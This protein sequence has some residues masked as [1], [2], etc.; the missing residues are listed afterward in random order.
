MDEGR[1]GARVVASA[2]DLRT[3]AWLRE[4]E[5]CLAREEAVARAPLTVALDR[6][7]LDAAVGRGAPLTVAYFGGFGDVWGGSLEGVDLVLVPHASSIDLA[8]RRGAA[9][10]SIEVV[11]PLGLPDEAPGEDRESALATLLEGV[12]L[13]PDA[14]V[15]VVDAR[16][17][18]EVGLRVALAQLALVA[19]PALFVFDVG[20][21]V[22]LADE[23][24]R[25]VPRF[26]LFAALVAEPRL[27][28]GLLRAAD[29]ALV[30]LDDLRALVATGGET[31]LLVL[32][33]TSRER[34][35]VE[36]LAR[37]GVAR[38]SSHLALLAVTI[39]AALSVDALSAARRALVAWQ[40]EA[41]GER[42]VRAL[43]ALIERVERAPR[44]LPE[45]VELLPREPLDAA[46]GAIEPL[47]TEEKARRADEA[48]QIEDELEALK[49]R[50]S[51]G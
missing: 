22:A 18:Q 3:S 23:L 42:I 28:H 12:E 26:G 44:G 20:D 19:L 21:D 29:L 13:P 6:E 27:A 51:G 9:R 17:L 40:P 7:S 15:V 48:R 24:R 16:V 43:A 2:N 30:R 32:A 45:G 46:S 47:V 37:E 35:A 10:A 11:G 34:A 25:I 49:Q 4:L 31:G 50:I 41:T 36:A 14:R 1:E 38:V 5:R 8:L 39:D 33:P